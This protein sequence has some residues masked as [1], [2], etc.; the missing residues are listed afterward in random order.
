MHCSGARTKNNRKLFH[1]PWQKISFRVLLQ[2]L[3]FNSQGFPDLQLL[4]QSVRRVQ[5]FHQQPP[6]IFYG[7]FLGSE[8]KN[9]TPVS[10][11]LPD[12]ALR[13][14]IIASTVVHFWSFVC[15]MRALNQI[16]LFK[17]TTSG[18]DFAMPTTFINTIFE[19][20]FCWYILYLI[21]TWG[22]TQKCK[23]ADLVLYFER[24]DAPE[25]KYIKDYC[26]VWQT[27]PSWVRG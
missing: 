18:R 26:V 9:F 7:K 2:H 24:D 21:K 13:V 3:F 20:V 10:H 1:F 4:V 15:Q 14:N 25:M 6:P 27:F 23:E 16:T 22:V 5:I 19:I 8:R 17:S 12:I 11:A